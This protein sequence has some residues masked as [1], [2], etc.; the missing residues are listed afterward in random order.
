MLAADVQDAV[1]LVYLNEKMRF[2]EKFSLFLSGIV[3]EMPYL[4]YFVWLRVEL[5]LY[6][7]TLYIRINSSN[8]LFT[9]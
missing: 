1:F 2:S 8:L 9:I 5:K 7:I 3:L 4:S 6:N